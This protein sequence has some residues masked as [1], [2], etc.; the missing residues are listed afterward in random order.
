MTKIWKA[1][2]WNCYFLS[3]VKSWTLY[4]LSMLYDQNFE[5]SQSWEI[6]LCDQHCPSLERLLSMT[7]TGQTSY[8][9][10]P[11]SK[12]KLIKYPVSGE[13]VLW[14]MLGQ[15]SLEAFNAMTKTSHWET[16]SMN[17][18]WI[19]KFW[20]LWPEHGLNVKESNL[21]ETEFGKPS[22]GDM[23]TGWI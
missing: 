2:S 3:L 13:C 23:E 4:F 17:K 5:S 9:G 12:I 8:D 21:L 10:E 22:L 20:I 18:P 16:N 15:P 6:Q 1:K 19:N 7:Q 14:P 11:N